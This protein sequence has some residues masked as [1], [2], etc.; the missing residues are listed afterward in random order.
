MNQHNPKIQKPAGLV[1]AICG[2]LL[3]GLP[4]IPLA[5]SAMPASRVNPCDYHDSSSG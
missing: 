3:I 5:A 4:A 1:S 2:S